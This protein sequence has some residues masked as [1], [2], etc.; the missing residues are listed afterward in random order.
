MDLVDRLACVATPRKSTAVS[1]PR[2]SG[3]ASTSSPRKS[4]Q[5]IPKIKG[6][7]SSETLD[8]WSKT[9]A[10]A[11]NCGQLKCALGRLDDILDYEWTGFEFRLLI[12]SP[13]QTVEMDNWKRAQRVNLDLYVPLSPGSPRPPT[14]PLSYLDYGYLMATWFIPHPADVELLETPLE[15]RRSDLEAACVSFDR[16]IQFAREAG[17]LECQ[18]T[19]VCGGHDYQPY[20]D[21][22]GRHALLACMAPVEEWAK[23]RGV[24]LSVQVPP[25]HSIVAHDGE[26]RPYLFGHLIASWM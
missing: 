19:T 18:L 13:L 25:N 23:R 11:R 20:P 15:R 16:R 24:T 12:G 7:P 14:Y 5:P 22:V 10:S 8:T 3:S 21:H 9:V 6:A 26:V 4:I 1:S 17:Q 2:K